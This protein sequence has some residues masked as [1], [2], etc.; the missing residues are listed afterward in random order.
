ML[1]SGAGGEATGIG[2][3]ASGIGG[4]DK[5]GGAGW[6]GSSAADEWEG[7]GK[8]GATGSCEAG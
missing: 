6:D 5:V 8:A 7:G 2:G 3:M 4:C 1:K